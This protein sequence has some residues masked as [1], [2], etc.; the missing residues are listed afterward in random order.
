MRKCIAN[1]LDYIEYIAPKFYSR[2]VEAFCCWLDPSKAIMHFTFKQACQNVKKELPYR[3]SL[4][5]YEM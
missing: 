3:S 4:H 1:L 2:Y 5:T